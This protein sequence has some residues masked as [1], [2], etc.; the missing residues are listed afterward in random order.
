MA[1]P[2]PRYVIVLESVPDELSKQQVRDLLVSDFGITEARV[3]ELFGSLPA[4]VLKDVDEL[5]AVRAKQK[6]VWCGAEV[7]MQPVPESEP[8]TAGRAVAPGPQ[9]PPTSEPD[10]VEDMP[11]TRRPSPVVEPDMPRSQDL[12]VTPPSDAAPLPD[13]ASAL[14]GARAKPSEADVPEPEDK[15]EPQEQKIAPPTGAWPRPGTPPIVSETRAA[16]RDVPPAQHDLPRAQEQGDMDRQAPAR[17]APKPRAPEQPPRYEEP[18]RSAGDQAVRI[19]PRT[20]M[21]IASPAEERVERLRKTI[22]AARQ[23]GEGPTIMPDVP[24][25][26]RHARSFK[27]Y[28][29]LC[30]ALLAIVFLAM[31]FIRPGD[32]DGLAAQKEATLLRTYQQ[33]YDEGTQQ[34]LAGKYQEAV[35]AFETA[36]DHIQRREA[37]DAAARVRWKLQLATARE[38][39]EAGQLEEARLAYEEAERQT[40]SQEG[41]EGIARTMKLIA[42]RRAAQEKAQRI[43]LL[44]S[45]AERLEGRRDWR[46]L[47]GALE[48]LRATQGDS[49]ALQKR[50]ELVKLRARQA[51]LADEEAR[52]R[53]GRDDKARAWIE[54]AQELLAKGMKNQAAQTARLA[55]LLS[56]NNP[57]ALDI[58]EKCTGSRPAPTGKRVPATTPKAER[59]G[60]AAAEGLPTRLGKGKPEAPKP[61]QPATATPRP[62]PKAQPKR[63]ASPKTAPKA[64]W[65]RAKGSTWQ[66]RSPSDR[67]VRITHR[68]LGP[69]LCKG[70]S[71]VAYE[72]TEV[73][74]A[75]PRSPATK[76]RLLERKDGLYEVLESGDTVKRYDLP[77]RVGQS[78]SYK[79]GGYATQDAVAQPAKVQVHTE[80]K[81]TIETP[82]GRFECFVVSRMSRRKRFVKR[83]A[84]IIQVVQVQTEWVCPGVGLAKMEKVSTEEVM[85]Q[86]DSGRAIRESIEL[87]SYSLK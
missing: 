3:P 69:D 27:P 72:V 51:D 52:L 44:K 83:T 46:G 21:G 40:T 5:E 29:M 11:T 73:G 23:D 30:L 18:H 86:K 28:A 53:E 26:G 49:P 13:E 22:G 31:Y 36:F 61:V 33:W 15:P 39:E 66:Y 35:A 85:G 24:A 62:G 81:E 19:P 47:V 71:C 37:Q 58:V 57:A 8:E 75:K 4:V 74:G 43:E 79:V 12:R 6:L 65:P 45:E 48:E 2:E 9:E 59:P 1:T 87:A 34:E 25:T 38:A 32:E 77:L 70:V 76:V 78:F 50:L 17:E 14:Q 67:R 68:V 20:A 7:S 55:L 84:E 10:A 60:A 54:K 63:A 41:R 42:A 56:P 82:A 64:F 80:R 16:P